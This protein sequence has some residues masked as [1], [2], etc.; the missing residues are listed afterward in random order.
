MLEALSRDTT[1]I[2]REDEQARLLGLL[3]G[4]R[5]H[6]GGACVLVCG[7]AGVGKTSL[8]REVRQHGGA[9]VQWLWGACEPLLTAPPLG[10]LIELAE[11]LPPSLAAA[12]RS[13]RQT[14]EVLAGLLALLRERASPAV[15]LIDDAHW[16]DDAT[17]D[18]LRYIG[19]RIE[20]TRALLVLTYRDAELGADHPLLGVLGSLP[21]RECVRIKLA[22]LT[23]EGVAELARRAGRSAQGV[24][25]A[26]RGNPFFVT[27]LLAG[28]AQ[29]LPASVRDAVRARAGRLWPAAREVLDLVSVSATPLECSVLDAVLPDA[30]AGAA[31]CISAGLLQLD[32][33]VLHFRHELARLS[34]ESAL[35]PPRVVALHA[36]L[37]DALSLHGAAPNRLVHHAEHGGLEGAVLRLAPQAARD[38]ALALAHRQAAALYALTLRHATEWPPLERAQLLL[39]RADECMLTGLVQDAVDARLQA[40]HLHRHLGDTLAE[41]IA[42]HKLA[43]AEWFRGSRS[44][45]LA[46]AQASIDV[47]EQHAPG[48][49]ELAM[50]YATLAQLK[51][52]DE[53]STAAREWGLRALAVFEPQDDAE[54]L[55]YAL[56]TVG[57]AELR[58][59]DAPHAWQRLERSLA[60]SLA[61]GLEEHAARAYT[62]LASMALVH[63]RFA[64]LASACDEGLAYAQSRDIDMYVAR[65]RIRR[66]RAD[67]E[68]GRWSEAEHGLQLVRSIRGLTPLEDEQSA[69]VAALLD[70]RRGEPGVQAYWGALIEG[71]H[72]LSV[73]PW[74]TPQAVVCAEAAWL[75][76]RNDDVQRIAGAAL[77]RAERQ[78]ERWRT[79][80]LACWLARIGRLPQAF[81]VQVAAPCALE[82]AGDHRGAAAAW[83]ELGCVYEQALALIG[84]DAGDLRAALELLDGLGA[85]PAACI[86]RRRLRSLGLRDVPRGPYAHTRSD[87]LG[88]TAR[89]RQV[90]DLVAAGL[91]NRAIAARLH[92]SERTVENHVAAVLAKLGATSRGEAVALAAQAAAVAEK[93]VPATQ[94]RVAATLSAQ[95]CAA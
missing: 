35:S 94:N 70:L 51:L 32:G 49:R 33:G 93:Q 17:L 18:L 47:L 74:Y 71:A 83:A 64:Q 85:A 80:Q 24:H 11:A 90:L 21:S 53:T 29:S 7:E 16:A 57:T 60:V 20:S 81:A 78:A 87:A 46:Y 4:L 91:S 52:L 95:T 75:A 68:L 82:L 45:A 63:R 39:A 23:A 2:E 55:A 72:A 42:L 79:G 28:D 34:V 86:A 26:T 41:G 31:E 59:H 15:L 58:T 9:D 77:Q 12:V 61:H 84:G 48:Q 44:A 40:L 66:A 69:H 76:G 89:E 27:E 54:G 1:L 65:L 25:A 22:P 37:F 73:D 14:P 36:A 3:A 8:L 19:R 13:G 10:P 67:L 88:L 50:A 92:R 30:D 38:A 43:R 6:A 62:N 56:N 5:S